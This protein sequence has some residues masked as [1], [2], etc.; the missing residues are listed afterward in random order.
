MQGEAVL[1]LLKLSRKGEPFPV[2]AFQREALLSPS[3]AENLLKK[4]ADEGLIK[5]RNS[6]IHVPSA[7]KVHLLILALRDGVSL[8]RACKHITWLDFERVAV[9]ALK[10][11]GYEVALHVRLKTDG[12]R[13]EADIIA[14]KGNLMLL[15]DCKHWRKPL[16]ESNLKRLLEKQK[17]R[18]RLMT[19]AENVKFFEDK[20]GRKV[21][22]K[23]YVIPVVLTLLEER[24]KT[25]HGM[26]IVPVFKMASFLS[27]LPAYI[28]QLAKLAIQL[29]TNP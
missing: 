23:F 11:N 5:I 14:L 4:L 9:E 20:I 18:I 22:R 19:A 10:V 12:S 2:E 1:S 8:E 7:R 16:Y 15:I 29:E 6:Q 24:H 28:D 17:T 3:E 27:E 25:Y 21:P 26:P 13:S